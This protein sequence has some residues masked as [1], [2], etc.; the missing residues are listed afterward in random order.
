MLWGRETS[1]YTATFVW[2]SMSSV[3][4]RDIHMPH[5][6]RCSLRTSRQGDRQARRDVVDRGEDPGRRHGASTNNSL[7]ASYTNK[8]PRVSECHLRCHSTRNLYGSPGQA[9]QQLRVSHSIYFKYNL[10]CLAVRRSVH[11][12]SSSSV[13]FLSP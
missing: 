10:L 2:Q 7:G 11:Y 6:S 1:S 12:L 5:D 13:S 3:K 4:Q 8:H 9:C